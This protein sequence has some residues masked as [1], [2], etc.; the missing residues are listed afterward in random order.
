VAWRH[1]RN[2]HPCPPFSRSSTEEVNQLAHVATYGRYLLGLSVVRAEGRFGAATRA[3]NK[4]PFCSRVSRSTFRS[5]LSFSTAAPGRSRCGFCAS[6]CRLGHGTRRQPISTGRGCRQRPTHDGTRGRLSRSLDGWE[7]DLGRGSLEPRM[8]AVRT[9]STN[10]TTRPTKPV[11]SAKKLAA[12][13]A[14]TSG[15]IRKPPARTATLWI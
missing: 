11:M 15:L 3:G 1:T 12:I 2:C 13:V 5:V 8:R 14:H 4:C 6:R 10:T 9:S 7:A